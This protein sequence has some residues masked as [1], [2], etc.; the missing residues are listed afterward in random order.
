MAGIK[1]LENLSDE[2]INN[3]LKKGAKFVIFSYTI[4]IIIM[5][6]RRNSD[7]YFIKSGESAV[8]YSWKYSLITFFAGWWGIPFGPIFSIASFYKNFTGGKDVTAEVIRAINSEQ[9]MNQQG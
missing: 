4:S 3:E 7:I 9:P 6:F 8:A 1:N 2:Q 5:T